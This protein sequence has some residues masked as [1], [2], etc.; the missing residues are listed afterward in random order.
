MS[1]CITME[2]KWLFV[3]QAS[4]FVGFSVRFHQ[5]CHRMPR[6]GP[7]TKYTTLLSDYKNFII[8]K[9]QTFRYKLT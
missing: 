3:Y 2:T 7:S 5:I 6:T 4:F 1:T 9:I 8:L